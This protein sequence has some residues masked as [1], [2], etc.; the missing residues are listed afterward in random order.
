MGSLASGSR[1]DI[2]KM[3]VAWDRKSQFV[4]HLNLGILSEM[5][6]A[7][8]WVTGLGVAIDSQ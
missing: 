1:G 2:S 8:H 6:Q 4:M 5:V 7:W 3:H